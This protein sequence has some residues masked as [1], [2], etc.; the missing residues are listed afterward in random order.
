MV[1]TITTSKDTAL[2]EA[3]R[4]HHTGVVQILI[5][6]DPDFPYSANEAGETPLY[7]AAERGYQDVVSEIL[8]TCMSIAH[9]GPNGRTSLHAAAI[10]NDE[11]ITKKILDTN[12]FLTSEAD[13]K[14]WTPLHYAAY[15][16]H[17]SVLKQLLY[18]DQSQS[19]VYIGDKDEKKTA[20]HIAASHG[21]VHVMNE[22]L[23]YCP[24]CCEL[25]DHKGRNVVHFAMESINSEQ[26]VK[27][28]IENSS[29]CS[30]INETD[31]G[32]MASKIKNLRTPDI[33]LANGKFSGLKRYTKERMEEEGGK[34]SIPKDS[35]N[36][37]VKGESNISENEQEKY[38]LEEHEGSRYLEEKESKEE[39]ARNMG[40]EAKNKRTEVKG[41]RIADISKKMRDTNLIAATLIA[42]VT[43]T[44]GFTMPGGFNTLGAPILIRTKAFQAFIITNTLAMV[45]S[46]SSVAFHLF[47]GRRRKDNLI[48][49]QTVDLM[50]GYT[51]ISMMCMAIAFVTGTYAVLQ[52]SFAFAN[53]N[54]ICV[55]G[56]LLLCIFYFVATAASDQAAASIAM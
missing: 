16:G 46:S 5:R 9:G 53:A 37:E 54:A 39:E 49:Y 28:I 11:V 41:M 42:T 55:T 7:L 17:L 36:L 3:V 56:C 23:S 20:L 19:A 47:M 24:D 25:V 44:A 15:F 21:H 12:W 13:H 31:S 14:G 27:F 52:R 10:F 51:S 4:H 34:S 8:E 38:L 45:F 18:Y 40:K 22:L 43:F 26:V 35:A 2:H 6:E 32:T 33:F 50:L 29:L 48:D 1:R 30:L